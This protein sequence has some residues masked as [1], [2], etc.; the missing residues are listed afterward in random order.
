MTAIRFISGEAALRGFLHDFSEEARGDLVERGINASG[1]LSKSHRVQV[2]TTGNGTVGELLGLGYW[3]KA[4]SGSPPGTV[5]N[6]DKLKEWA[7][8]KGIAK[9]VDNPTRFAELVQD[10]IYTEGSKDFRERNPNVYRGAAK[11]MQPR[12]PGVIQAF[13]SDI[14]KPMGEVFTAAFKVA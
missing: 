5:A 10:K 14:P 7:L 13:L 2:T 12:V 3:T 4:G 1:A 11:R 6:L 9:D 8:V